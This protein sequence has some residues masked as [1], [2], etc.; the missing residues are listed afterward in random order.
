MGATHSRDSS[1]GLSLRRRRSRDATAESREHL[2]SSSLGSCG[3]GQDTALPIRGPGGT[4][5]QS[6]IP[7][8][9]D[10]QPHLHPHTWAI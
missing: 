8:D 5:A 7:A 1:L 4:T 6:R 3:T 10:S 9:P 2:E